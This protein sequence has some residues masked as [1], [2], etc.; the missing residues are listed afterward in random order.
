MRGDLRH[1]RYPGLVGHVTLE[2]AGE[3]QEALAAVMTG[4]V[5]EVVPGGSEAFLSRVRRG[6][7]G[8]DLHSPWLE[9]PLEGLSRAA[10][11]CGVV[12]DLA[13]AF[14]DR[15]RGCLGLHC[16]AVRI[17]GRL[18]ALT[19]PAR[20]GKSTLMARLTAEPDMSVFCDDILPV[21]ED[22][23]AFGLGFAPRLRLPLPDTV[24]AGFR[25]HVAAHLGPS[26]GRY[27]YL[28]GPNIAP[29]G[30]RAPLA[31]L[32]VLARGADVPARLHRMEASEAVHHL[33]RQN[34]AE[35]GEGVAH[36]DR[37]T[38]MAGT[39]LCLKLVYSDLEEAVALLRHAFGGAMMPAP[40]L[41]L[42][43]PLPAGIAA[44]V[45]SPAGLE[46][47]FR[48]SPQVALRAV[49]QEMFLWHAGEQ[50]Y[51]H[52][53]PVAR[54][55]WTLLEER[56]TGAGIAGVLCEAFPDVAAARVRTDV[57]LLLGAFEAEGLI[58]PAG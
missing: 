22:G 10:A 42:G 20:A 28:C 31:A 51:F 45:H 32:V 57:A 52:L 7:D 48:R 35:P 43:P 41:E 53:N 21:L 19:G 36:F 46:R 27:G 14:C 37:V 25:A 49:G 30:T 3:V 8:F 38:R 54:A 1:L 50:S 47:V 55:V 40:D 9:E 56:V 6:R 23:L 5:P 29:H 26:D 4:W 16:G 34:I 12:A 39:L 58:L 24:S 33:M 17:A 18:V 44:V 11:A 15:H 2:E 13:Q